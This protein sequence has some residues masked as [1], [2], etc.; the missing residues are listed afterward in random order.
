MPRNFTDSTEF[1]ARI[2]DRLRQLNHPATEL[3]QKLIMYIAS[4]QQKANKATAIALHYNNTHE[5]KSPPDHLD[6]VYSFLREEGLI[7]KDREVYAV[8]EILTIMEQTLKPRE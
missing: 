4:L 1:I 5:G 8:E 7:K 2:R 3:E 6:E